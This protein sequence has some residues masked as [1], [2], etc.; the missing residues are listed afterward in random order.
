MK[1]D[2]RQLGEVHSIGKVGEVR[3]VHQVRQP[4][5]VSLLNDKTPEKSKFAK[6]STA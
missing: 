4:G 1:M 2:V 6:R 3:Q 5:K